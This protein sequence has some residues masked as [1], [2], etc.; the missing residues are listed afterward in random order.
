[1]AESPFATRFFVAIL[2]I[3]LI[4]GPSPSRAA[5]LAAIDIPITVDH[6]QAVV[7]VVGVNGGYA[8]HPPQLVVVSVPFAKGAVPDD[9]PLVA[10]DSYDR[11]LPTESTLL[12]KWADGSIYFYATPLEDQ[13]PVAY[14]A[15]GLFVMYLIDQ[16]GLAKFKEFY[17]RTD[18]KAGFLEVYEGT[19][20][21]A[22]RQW[23]ETLRD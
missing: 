18:L 23:K 15:S 3:L 10:Y 8:W 4:A 20:S 16:H 5:D 6:G 2:P 13:W 19:L 22:V 7:P 14:P 9:T 1:M 12:S 11:P 17:P 21:D